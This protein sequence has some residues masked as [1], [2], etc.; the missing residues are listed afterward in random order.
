[1]FKGGHHFKG[2]M[3]EISCKMY[4]FLNLPLLT[5]FKINKQK[6]FFLLLRNDATFIFLYLLNKK[7]VTPIA[8]KQASLSPFK[9]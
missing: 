9:P 8:T 2:N 1:M 7:C 3:T 6:M 5:D 4:L